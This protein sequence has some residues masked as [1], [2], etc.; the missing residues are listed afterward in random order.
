MVKVHQKE[1]AP[2]EETIECDAVEEVAA[3]MEQ[4]ESESATEDCPVDQE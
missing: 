2:A 4:P 3:P 1:S